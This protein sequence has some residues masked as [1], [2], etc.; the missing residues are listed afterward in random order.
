M[1]IAKFCNRY[2]NPFTNW[3]NDNYDRS[4]VSPKPYGCCLVR[5]FRCFNRYTCCV[6][7]CVCEDDVKE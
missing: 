1:T 4:V 6:Y 5:I 3:K 2:L 7:K